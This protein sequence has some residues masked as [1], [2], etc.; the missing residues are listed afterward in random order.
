VHYVT[1]ILKN[2]VWPSVSLENR[3]SRKPS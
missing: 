2:L 3:T 1:V